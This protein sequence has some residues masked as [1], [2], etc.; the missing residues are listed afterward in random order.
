MRHLIFAAGTVHIVRSPRKLFAHA[1]ASPWSISLSYVMGKLETM[2]QKY[3]ISALNLDWECHS[4]IPRKCS[5][6]ECFKNLLVF[7]LRSIPIPIPAKPL[8]RVWLFTRVRSGRIKRMEVV[9]VWGL[10][11]QNWLSC[12][13]FLWSDNCTNSISTVTLKLWT[14]DTSFKFTEPIPPLN[15]AHWVTTSVHSSCFVL[16]HLKPINCNSGQ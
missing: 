9:Q 4:E 16:L 13:T 15:V 10:Y 8:P 11:Y 3:H 2:S 7:W 5:Y 14:L 1:M 12:H 6:P